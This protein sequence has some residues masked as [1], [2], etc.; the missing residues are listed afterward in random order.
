[1]ADRPAAS[2]SGHW[3][4][5]CLPQSLSIATG[6]RFPRLIPYATATTLAVL[7]FLLYMLVV[8]STP[9]A[10]NH[11]TPAE[12][13]GLNPL[14]RDPGMLIHP[15]L[16]LGGFASFTV[17]FSIVIAA[18]ITG[19]MGR[20]W[21]KFVRN[22][23][24]ISWG[25]L[26][27]GIFLGGWWAYHVLGWGGYWAWDPVENVSILPWFTV[28]AFIHSIIVQERRGMLKVWNVGLILASF[29]LAIMGTFIVRS[30]L[31]SSV[32]AFA[33]SDVGGYFLGS[34]SW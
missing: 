18:L 2:C 34:S 28:T 31:I 4:P 7:G 30:G 32:H 22:W 3:S 29:I 25:I 21:L 19:R 27:A 13:R 10:V 6:P 33:L 5:R 17:P 8:V 16:L 26:S 11:I 14:L 23:A 24:L 12:G 20:E 1:M 9:F 15:P